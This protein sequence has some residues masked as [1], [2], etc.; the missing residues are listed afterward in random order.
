MN[1]VTCRVGRTVACSMVGVSLV[2]LLAS[3]GCGSG[4]PKTVPVT[5]VV[6]LDGS[7][8][9]GAA[10]KLS[11]KAGGRPASG[12]T[13]KEGVFTLKTFEEGDGALPGEHLVTVSKVEV[14]GAQADKDG[15]SGPVPPG[16]IKEKWI[17]PKRY[18]DAKGWG[19]TV[20]VKSGME[21]LELELTSH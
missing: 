9:E 20:E 14:I 7:V 6:T 13:N 18:S 10:V 1:I 19:R 16:G 4:R 5:G 15:L 8:V 21:P 3:A 17:I 2:G 12:T 11:P